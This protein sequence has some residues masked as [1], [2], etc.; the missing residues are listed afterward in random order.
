MRISGIQWDHG[1]L[2]GCN[3]WEYDRNMYRIYHGNI[4]EYLMGYVMD[5][6]DGEIT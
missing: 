4:M 2:I 3:E 5:K 6:Y 1:N